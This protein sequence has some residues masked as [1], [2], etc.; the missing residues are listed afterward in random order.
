MSG[1]GVLKLWLAEAY[2]VAVLRRRKK[3]ACDHGGV[4]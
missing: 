3:S 1:S 2:Q 4:G